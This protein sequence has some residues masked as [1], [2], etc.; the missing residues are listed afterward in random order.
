MSTHGASTGLMYES[1]FSIKKKQR[2]SEG[3]QFIT[4]WGNGEKPLTAACNYRRGSICSIEMDAKQSHWPQAES[5][6]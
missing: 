6:R 1:G 5:L 4:T 2:E 3:V